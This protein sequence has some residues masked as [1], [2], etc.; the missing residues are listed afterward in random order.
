MKGSYINKSTEV[1]TLQN[2]PPPH[3]RICRDI[4]SKELFTFTVC[5]LCDRFVIVRLHLGVFW[6][7]LWVGGLFAF[8]RFFLFEPSSSLPPF[9]SLFLM[10]M[11]MYF[12]SCPCFYFSSFSFLFSSRSFFLCF[13]FFSF[14]SCSSAFLSLLY[15]GFELGV[16]E[17]GAAM[18]AFERA[19]K[20]ERGLEMFEEMVCKRKYA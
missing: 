16:V 15:A 20:P 13:F 6:L 12:F 17:Y 18:E 3:K 10:C 9:S 11:C 14:S 4:I 19:G 8:S 5:A 2:P 1:L 7:L